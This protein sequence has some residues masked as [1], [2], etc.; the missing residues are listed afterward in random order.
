MKT[1]GQK[2]TGIMQEVKTVLKDATI[3]IGNQSY[4]V[5]THDMVTSVLHEPMARIGVFTKLQA[6]DFELTVRDYIDTYGKPK[7]EYMAKAMMDIYFI[8]S[9]DKEDFI[10]VQVP[11]Y[12]FDQGDKAVGKMLSM[13]QKYALL[14]TF[15]LESTDEEESR[16]ESTY[17]QKQI[18]LKKEAYKP[19]VST[20]ESVKKAEVSKIETKPITASRTHE[21][22]PTSLQTEKDISALIGSITAKLGELTQGQTKEQKSKFMSEKLGMKAYGELMKMPYAELWTV[23]DKLNKLKVN[24]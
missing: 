16:P 13:A 22:T 15:M 9:D 8:N 2:I 18:E 21:Q 4:D 3:T 11:G 12:A 10:L 1:I 20:A 7:R 6:R 14:K 19:K 17:Q 5:I 23:N 24:K